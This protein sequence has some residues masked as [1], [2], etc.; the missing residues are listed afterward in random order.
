MQCSSP[1]KTE[2]VSKV[3]RDTVNKFGGFYNGLKILEMLLHFML[4]FPFVLTLISSSLLRL[5]VVVCIPWLVL[6]K[7]VKNSPATAYFTKTALQRSYYHGDQEF[8]YTSMW[9]KSDLNY[10]AIRG[11]WYLIE[12]RKCT[13]N[14]F[15]WWIASL[16]TNFNNI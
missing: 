14:N 11:K 1:R 7:V 4:A 2:F 15:S 12:I 6:D 16:K 10:T 9:N 5:V 13:W 3:K 8:C